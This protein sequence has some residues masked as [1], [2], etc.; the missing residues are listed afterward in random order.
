[1]SLI[2]AGDIKHYFFIPGIYLVFI[3][4]TIALSLVCAI[5]SINL[6][7]RDSEEQ[8]VPRLLEEIFF[9]KLVKLTQMRNWKSVNI[10]ARA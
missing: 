4:A 8:P 3:M 9:E 7:R 1:M 2:V 10:L 5:I 6:A